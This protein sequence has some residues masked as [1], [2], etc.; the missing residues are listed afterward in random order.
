MHLWATNMPLK[1]VMITPSLSSPQVRLRPL[2]NT[3]GKPD[4]ALYIAFAGR[5]HACPCMY[6]SASGGC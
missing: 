1:H 2:T 4:T 6:F 3:Q 5:K